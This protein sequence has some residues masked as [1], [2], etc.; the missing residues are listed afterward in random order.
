MALSTGAPLLTDDRR[1]ETM[2]APEDVAAM[3]RLKALG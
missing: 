3:L 1:R 2:K